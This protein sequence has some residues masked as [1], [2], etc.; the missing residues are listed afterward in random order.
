MKNLLIPNIIIKKRDYK[1][2]IIYFYNFYNF[3]II[4]V[5]LLKIITVY[6]KFF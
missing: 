1:K 2:D 5:L 6:A 4:F 3:K